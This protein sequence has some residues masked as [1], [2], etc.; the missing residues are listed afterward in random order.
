MYQLTLFILMIINNE[1]NDLQMKIRIETPSITLKHKYIQKLV[2]IFLE[3]NRVNCFF[4]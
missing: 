2:E 1:A 3:I 4:E